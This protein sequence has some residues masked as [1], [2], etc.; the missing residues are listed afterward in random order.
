MPIFDLLTPGLFFALNCQ[1]AQNAFFSFLGSLMLPVVLVVVLTC[2]M[3]GNC[4]NLG[5]ALGD[6]LGACLVLTLDILL[7]LFKTLVIAAYALFCGLVRFLISWHG[8]RKFKL[9]TGPEDPP[10][11]R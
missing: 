2:A 11:K 10:E 4:Q 8:H 3:G 7:R 5:E 6:A 1:P 9:K